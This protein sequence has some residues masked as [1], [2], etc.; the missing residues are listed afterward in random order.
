MRNKLQH[1]IS[2]EEIHYFE[3][4]G[5]VEEYHSSLH[6]ALNLASEQVKE[7]QKRNFERVKYFANSKASHRNEVKINDLRP[8]LGVWDDNKKL[9]KDIF[10]HFRS[11]VKRMDVPDI[12]GP[13][14]YLGAV[15]RFTAGK[16]PNT[17]LHT[18]NI[19]S[20]NYLEESQQLIT[21][22]QSQVKIWSMASLE[23]TKTYDIKPSS[24]Q[25]WMNALPRRGM[26]LVSSDKTLSAYDLQNGTPSFTATTEEDFGKQRTFNGDK[27]ALSSGGKIKLFNLESHDFSDE[28]SIFTGTA[29]SDFRFSKDRSKVFAIAQNQVLKIW[30]IEGQ[31]EV[32]T[33]PACGD[34]PVNLLA[35]EEGL[36][37]GTNSGRLIVADYNSRTFI[38][39]S[40]ANGYK[41]NT[42]EYLTCSRQLISGREHGL[43]NSYDLRSRCESGSVN[44]GARVGAS[45]HIKAAKVIA[46]TA[47]PQPTL[48]EY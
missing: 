1:L 11:V 14:N 47:G 43:V 36:V 27:V 3:S 41:I 34:V 19:G 29:I 23:C 37:I 22:D 7:K 32:L 12:E 10:A 46:E 2:G 5:T 44:L 21:S 25:Q 6:S 42:L 9:S 35:I 13:Y 17:A 8:S 26:I 28:Y 4:V 30:D 38:I 48:V 18:G 20:I 24:A 15:T 31:R 33:Y 40:Q 39:S 45:K 16:G